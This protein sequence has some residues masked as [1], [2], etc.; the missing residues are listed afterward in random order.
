[1]DI[2][3]LGD[4]GERLRLKKG[5]RVLAFNGTQPGRTS[6][7]AASLARRSHSRASPF[8]DQLSFE[9]GECRQHREGETAGCRAFAFHMPK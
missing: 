6:E 8:T 4:Y 2:E 3:G 9:F 5:A 1:M 7:V